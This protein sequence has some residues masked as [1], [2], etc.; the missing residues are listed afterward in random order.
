MD[1]TADFNCSSCGFN[2]PC[3]KTTSKTGDCIIENTLS[4][5]I[6]MLRNVNVLFVHSYPGLNEKLM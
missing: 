2:Y 6:K 5:D 4:Q 1:C 3:H